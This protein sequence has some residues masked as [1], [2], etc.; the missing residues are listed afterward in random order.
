MK[1]IIDQYQAIR[2]GIIQDVSPQTATFGNVVQPL[3]NTDNSTQ[4]DIG[5]IAMLRYASLDQAS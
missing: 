2:E 3:I 4:G 1:S 5:I